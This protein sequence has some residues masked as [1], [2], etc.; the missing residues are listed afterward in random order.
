MKLERDWYDID[1]GMT[2]DVDHNPF[3]DYPDE[4]VA[5]T[6]KKFH[7]KLTDAEKWESNRLLTSGVVQKFDSLEDYDEDHPI[8]IHLIV[9]DHKPPFLEG[10]SLH[11]GHKTEQIQV[12]RLPT[13][14]MAKSARNGSEW[15]HHLRHE[16]E[17][18]KW[19]KQRLQLAGTMLGNV[20][21]LTTADSEDS[22]S[23]TDPSDTQRVSPAQPPLSM[24]AQ[25]ASLPVFSVRDDLVNAI[26]ENSILIVV[27]ETGSGKTTQLTQ[28][29]VEAG[30]T[31]F[32]IIG[33]T[34]PR[35]VAAMSVA[36]RVSEEMG[37]A[38]GSEVGYSIRFEDCTSSK[39]IIKYMTDGILLR[40]LLLDP[41]LDKY[42]CIIMD[43][44]HER[45]LNTD[46]LMGLFKRVI[47]RRRDL[48]LIVTSATMNAEKFSAF[49]GAAPVFN[50]PGR[51][52]P[53][54]VYYSKSVPD[55]YV[56][57]AVKQTLNIHLT[58]PPGD[59][60]VFMTGQ[61][62]IEATCQLIAQRLE[63]MPSP[64]PLLILPIYSQLP[65][66]LQAKIFQPSKFRKCIVATNIAETSLT[67]NGIIYVIDTGFCKLKYFNST[68]GMDT[69]QVSPISQAQALQR[70]GRAGRNAPGVAFRLY[71]DSSFQ[72][73]FYENTIPEI[74]RTNLANV[75]LLLKS[76][77]V[78]N[79]L[80]F[81]FMDP[82][83]KDTL[84]SAMY[85]LWILGALDTTGELT[86][87]GH[88]MVAF[89]LEPSLSKLLLVSCELQCSLEM[90][91]IV[92]MLS[93]PN[94]FE[95]PTAS[96]QEADAARERFYVAESDHLTLLHVYLQWL[97]NKNKRWCDQNYIQYKAMLKA[98]EVRSQL[99]DMIKQ[100]KLA[101]HSCG[102]E[103]DVLRKCIC[104][105]YFH[106]ACQLKKLGVYQDLR[107]GMQCQLH[108]TSALFGMGSIPEYIVYH[109]LMLT[110]QPYLH[111]VTAVEPTWLAEMGPM[112][113][114]IRQKGVLK[115]E[116]EAVVQRAVSSWNLESSSSSS[117][118]HDRNSTNKSHPD[119]SWRTLPHPSFP[120]EDESPLH[121]TS[122]RS[123]GGSALNRSSF[124]VEKFNDDE[125]SLSSLSSSVSFSSTS[126]K[127]STNIVSV[128][129]NF[130]KRRKP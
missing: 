73:E 109:E 82:P 83:S 93:V 52:F 45:S 21:G 27:G 115:S 51:T 117:S 62:D 10:L 110:S 40:E 4:P 14:D 13:G 72:E 116:L 35:R 76:M 26:R 64:P 58:H 1:E 47:P 88:R 124:R 70:S 48:R 121:V 39:T 23:S 22:T 63:D 2:M 111:C 112:F 119:P 65:A 120:S 126:S 123:E 107:T 87:L 12:M 74:Q 86:S 67:I 15:V 100:Q 130:P 85:Q 102:Q 54:D 92:S 96:Q 94:V 66:D 46:V 20:M 68:I 55:D 89:P 104:S 50:I 77:G 105:A 108:P 103:W 17:K 98:D 128:G 53:V 57:A 37:V 60:L 7:H 42:A 3:G 91:Y 99:V 33:C 25:R 69:L 30:M 11:Q 44:A 34:Q 31:H 19:T 36:K 38:L 61:E 78:R 129:R 97:K 9:H 95:R 114:S 122:S 41:D 28:Y 90:V 101:L 8:K 24:K 81:N 125:T 80:H 71:T 43:E 29:L 59:V 127:K 32:G 6:S 79:L 118:T 49:F 5:S 16:R 75:V 84:L 106:H 56:E 18:K 113:F